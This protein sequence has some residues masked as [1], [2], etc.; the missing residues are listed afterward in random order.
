MYIKDAKKLI[1]KLFAIQIKTGKRFSI[2][3][4]SSPGVG[5]SEGV[6]QCAQELTQ[7]LQREVACNPFFLSTVESFDVRGFPLPFTPENGE[8][9]MG[10]TKAPWVPEEGQDFGLLFLDE[11]RQATHDVQKP[12][13]ELLLNGRVG[14]SELPKGWMVIA[15]SNREKDRSGVQRELAFIT[16]RRM[17]IEI[18][19]HLGSWVEWAEKKGI[20]WAAIA[21]AKHQPQIAFS[22]KVPDK[23]GPFA[24]PR[25]LVQA[26]YLIDELPME[27]MTEA[28]SGLLGEGAAAQFI[29]FLRVAQEVPDYADIV[30]DPEG[31]KLP[32]KDRPDA[33]YATM[34]MVAH[35]MDGRTS[36]EAMTY[37]Q[38]MPQ[39]F[40]VAG[41][42][43]AL[44]QHP[45][46]ANSKPFG[47]WMMKNKELMVN[48]NMMRDQ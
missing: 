21:F 27:L 43:G 23:P 15:A 18:E 11:F 28:T 40:Q 29:A 46:I 33:Q 35:C 41:L 17:Q 26:S 20:H 13:A 14:D 2:E 31:T 39:E 1:K 22:N 7:S 10:F 3:L 44:R 30:R 36:P 48:A 37:L 4:I 47:E 25:T 24:T 38:R 6:E 12:A 16:N 34:Q 8:P 42:K 5:K 19:A 45:Q 32:P 9:T